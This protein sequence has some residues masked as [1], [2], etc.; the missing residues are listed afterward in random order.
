MT[1]LLSTDTKYAAAQFIETYTGR[2][3]YPLAPSIEAVSIIDI[4]HALSNQC[5]YSGHTAFFYP[6]AQHCCLLAEYVVHTGGSALDAL[7]ILMHDGAET[8]LVDMPRPVKQHMPV[9]RQW[10]HAIQYVIREWMGWGNLPIP[11]WQDELDSR[12]IVDER[13]QI[14]SRSGNDWGHNIEP[15][16]IRIEPWTPEEAEQTFLTQ[17]AAYSHAVY[18]SHQYLNA[19]WGIPAKLH[20]SASSDHAEVEDVMEVD[21]RG[22]VARIKLRDQDGRMVRDPKAGAFPTPD[23]QWLHGKFQLVE[24]KAA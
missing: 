5:R 13:A 11:S 20:H 21:V 7:Q 2:A 14:M 18:G 15:L 6:T 4:A 1:A 16:G 9:F 17:Y 10:D 19:E 22:G 8:Y 23:F 12:I 24:P 3:F